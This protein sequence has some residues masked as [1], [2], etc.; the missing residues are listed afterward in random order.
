MSHTDDS[1][2]GEIVAA[3]SIQRQSSYVGKIRLVEFEAASSGVIYGNWQNWSESSK[4][5]QQ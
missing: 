5:I 2:R 4:F 1:I 3:L